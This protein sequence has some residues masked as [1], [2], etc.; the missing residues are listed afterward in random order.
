MVNTNTET[1]DV[2]RVL[3]LCIVYLYNPVVIGHVY[4]LGVVWRRFYPA[5]FLL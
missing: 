1:V 3:V 5:V 2:L 4:G